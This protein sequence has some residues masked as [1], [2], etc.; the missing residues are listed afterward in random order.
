[1]RK[2]ISDEARQEIHKLYIEG[3]R[4]QDIAD[5]YSCTLQH[6]LKIIRIMEGKPVWT[7]PHVAVF[8]NNN[9][10]G[11]RMWHYPKK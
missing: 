9:A 2:L 4:A 3:M 8:Y 1:M 5:R 10:H 7:K 11:Q 6:I